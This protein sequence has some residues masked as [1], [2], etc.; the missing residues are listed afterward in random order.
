MCVSSKRILEEGIRCKLLAVM[1]DEQNFECHPD[2][3][4]KLAKLLE[5][6][7]TEAG[8]N[9]GFKCRMDGSSK[10]GKNWYEIH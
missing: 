8:R 2:D 6:T 10:I 4:K 3:S 9:L 1:H 5:E 7:A